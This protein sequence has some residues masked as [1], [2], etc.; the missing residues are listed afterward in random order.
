M[1]TQMHQWNAEFNP[2]SL[3]RLAGDE[4]TAAQ[5]VHALGHVGQAIAA[6]FDRHRVETFAIILHHHNQVIS[7]PLYLQK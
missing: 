7:L 2:A 5:F 3:A 4:A 6:W 1:P